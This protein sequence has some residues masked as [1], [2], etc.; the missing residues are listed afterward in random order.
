M[1]A[2][3]GYVFQH[4]SGIASAQELQEM[5]SDIQCPLELP[6][7]EKEAQA[8]GVSRRLAV[9]TAEKL[10][11]RTLS[12]IHKSLERTQAMQECTMSAF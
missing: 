12:L 1:Q 3:C 5:E 8:E 4:L 7:S 9:F 6:A 10:S 11:S 2:Y